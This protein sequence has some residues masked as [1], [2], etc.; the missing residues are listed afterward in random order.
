ME[1]AHKACLSLTNHPDCGLFGV[2]DGHLGFVAARWVAE[3]LEDHVGKL[4][5]FDQDSL[6]V[7]TTVL[8]V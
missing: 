6:K 5:V 1:D 2:F 7:L 4:N 3:N 8:L